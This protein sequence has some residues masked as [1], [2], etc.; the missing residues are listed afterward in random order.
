M[1]VNAGGDTQAAEPTAADSWATAARKPGGQAAWPALGPRLPSPHPE[2]GT[3]GCGG[4]SWA[5]GPEVPGAPVITCGGFHGFS[6]PAGAAE[7]L[8]GAPA[9]GG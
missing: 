2:L 7:L 1:P 5:V 9:G 8:S 3:L 4:R 6:R